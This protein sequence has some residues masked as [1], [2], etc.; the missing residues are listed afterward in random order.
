MGAHRIDTVSRLLA[1]GARRRTLL[2][3]IL[4]LAAL[5]PPRPGW[6]HVVTC[7]IPEC[8][9]ACPNTDCSRDPAGHCVCIIHDHCADL[10]PGCCVGEV[11]HTPDPANRRCGI[12]GA[13]CRTC[14]RGKT[15]RPDGRCR[16]I[17]RRHR[18]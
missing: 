6:A 9:D 8:Q 16:R 4:A 5:P 12:G 15:C 1:S 2:A 14:R 10:C 17:R 7:A 13:P 3:G 11:C 18:R